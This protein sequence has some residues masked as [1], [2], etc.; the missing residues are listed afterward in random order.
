MECPEF[1]IYGNLVA[2][3]DVSINSAVGGN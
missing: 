3:A 1:T 2:F